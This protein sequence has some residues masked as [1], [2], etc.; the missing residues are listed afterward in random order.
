MKTDNVI[1]GLHVLRAYS[2]DPYAIGVESD[3]CLYFRVMYGE[4][5]VA[6][7]RRLQHLGWF[8]HDNGYWATFL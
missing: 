2:R 1:E 6:D 7:L 4:V 8:R 5:R 3:D